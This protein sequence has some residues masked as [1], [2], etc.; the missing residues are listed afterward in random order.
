[1]SHF[2]KMNPDPVSLTKN[3]DNRLIRNAWIIPST[4]DMY[5][6]ILLCQPCED[7]SGPQPRKMRLSIFLFLLLPC[8]YS[9]FMNNLV[10]GT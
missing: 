4:Q 2:V 7:G 6:P 9:L 5:Y 1:M 3:G 10:S 8:V